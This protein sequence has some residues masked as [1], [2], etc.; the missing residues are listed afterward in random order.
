MKK[1]ILFL[2]LSISIHINSQDLEAE[3][4]SL[5]EPLISSGKNT[6]VSI[7]VYDLGA[8]YPRTFFF[9]KVAKEESAIP[10]E[11]TVYE[12]GGIT[13]TFT[14]T[15][16]QMLAL[17]GKMQITDPVQNYLPEGVTIHNFTSTE[18]IKLMHLVTHTSWLPRLPSNLMTDKKTDPK[19]PYANYN[20]EDLNT[21][22][23]NY[24]LEKEPGTRYLYSN[25][26]FGLLGNL[27]TRKTGKSYEEMLHY[28]ILDSLEM[29]STGITLT[30]EMKKNMAKG[31]TEKG[32]PQKLWNFD[33]LAGAGAIRST[34]KD[35]LK[36]L[37]FHMGKTDKMN[38]KESL[39]IMQKRRFDTDIDNVWIG[40]GWHISETSGG[41]QVIWHNGA[42]GGFT[43]CIAFMPEVQVGVV[44]LS[45]QASSVDGVCQSILKYL[46]R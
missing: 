30:P 19:D 26:G 32:E 38:F 10:D 41:K 27:M 25:L 36:Y 40:M 37:A 43:S 22:I 45:N 14:A 16:L 31:Y 44:V 18:E 46:N 3:I 28:Y 17:E 39:A 4:K 34:I 15:M 7:G 12:I 1:L 24:I 21:F 8:E 13:N 35:M 33:V 5:V 9:G 2:F 23:N 20:Q 6:S 42:T 11:N 29:T